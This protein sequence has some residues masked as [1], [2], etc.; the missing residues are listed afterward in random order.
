MPVEISVV[1]RKIIMGRVPLIREGTSCT[2][3]DHE[4]TI[5]TSIGQMCRALVWSITTS[6]T[7]DEPTDVIHTA[8]ATAVDHLTERLE[9][10]VK[11]IQE[12]G[13]DNILRM[14]TEDSMGVRLTVIPLAIA[15]GLVTILGLVEQGA[16]A[17][18]GIHTRPGPYAQLPR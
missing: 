16:R 7:L 3:T 10:M 18:M 1:D 8:L 2:K 4:A 5:A 14:R 12:V 13:K 17:K 11:P 6:E 9:M 15:V